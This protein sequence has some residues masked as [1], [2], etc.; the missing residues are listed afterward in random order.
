MALQ[1]SCIGRKYVP[2]LARLA[3]PAESPQRG[4]WISVEEPYVHFSVPQSI[5][6]SCPGMLTMT[7]RQRY[8]RVSA[9]LNR[10]EEGARRGRHSVSRMFCSRDRS[11]SGRAASTSAVM[12]PATSIERMQTRSIVLSEFNLVTTR[13]G[14]RITGTSSPCRVF[15]VGLISGFGIA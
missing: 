10:L 4:R 13:S 1:P 14:S 3:L 7:K 15:L 6:T 12:R 8:K 2:G 11:F 5:S 9:A